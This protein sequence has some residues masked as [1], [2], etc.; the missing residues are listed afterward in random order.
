[1]T[2][3][4]LENTKAYTLPNRERASIDL[5]DAENH[6]KG[7][8]VL[9]TGGGGTIGGELCRRIAEFEP[10][11]LIIGDICENGAFETWR[12]VKSNGFDDVIIE[13]FSVVDRKLS[14]RVFE[15]YS[16]DIV[17]HAAAH[18]HVPLMERCPAEAVKN[19]VFGTKNIMELSDKHN[20]QSF[21]L[22]STDKAV[23]PTSIMGTTKRIGELMVK[24]Y[25]RNSCT[26]FSAVR[27][28]NVFGSSGSAV[29]IFAEQIKAGGPVTVTS[30]NCKRYFMSV[31][32]AV[33]LVLSADAMS[34]GGKIFVLDMG[35]LVKIDDVAE[36]II[37]AFNLVP[38]KDIKIEYVG[39][40]KGEKTVEE[41][42]SDSEIVE[43]TKSERIFVLRDK[44]EL[45]NDLLENLNALEREV[46]KGNDSGIIR[47]L[48][49]IV[50]E[51]AIGE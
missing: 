20:V 34:D 30:P 10:K 6:I 29:R 46:I 19:N 7:R 41:L 45:P 43:K 11:L 25:A 26:K 16:P 40:R 36:N 23:N 47:E 49:N 2:E 50:P 28:G 14:E 38:D 44:S 32:E 51:C 4:L 18:K 21:I 8:T 33:E 31:S 35:E 17:Y 13:I 39:M 15:K 9:V 3:L 24:S 37:K 5:S 27:F 22:I 12:T 48:K 42:F 1:M